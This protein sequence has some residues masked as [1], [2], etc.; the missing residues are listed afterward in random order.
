MSIFSKKTEELEKK[1]FEGGAKFGLNQN[2]TLV[3]LEL[4]KTTTGKDSVHVKVD[5]SGQIK[6]QWMLV[7]VEGDYVNK[8]DKENSTFV[9]VKP[10]EEE[11]QGLLEKK[12][13]NVM[14]S[15]ISYLKA[16]SV[17]PQS[18]DKVI[19]RA[20]PQNFVQWFNAVTSLLP[21]DLSKY[22]ID[23]FLHWGKK[24][25]DGSQYLDIPKD[26]TEG[27]YFVCKHIPGNFTEVKDS[28]GLYYVTELGIEHPFKR[29][30]KWLSKPF[31][32]KEE[33]KEKKNLSITTSSNTW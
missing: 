16:V 5:I 32:N 7:P 8:W 28:K 26:H 17:E 22:P 18:I 29:T 13:E 6:R 4:V 31:A 21:K 23:I 11:Y 10:I 1:P 14:F 12:V 30:E 27:G 24:Q 25:D 20:K 2:V 19:E 33:E 9:E 15:V 3:S